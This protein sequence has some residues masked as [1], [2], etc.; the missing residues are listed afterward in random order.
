MSR[1]TSH[2]RPTAVPS[3]FTLVELLVVIGIIALLI[4]IL[5]PALS[6]ARE[7]G[8]AVK[9]MSNLRQ[10]YMGT[11]FYGLAFKGYTMP[12]TAGTGSAQNFN[13]WGIQVLGEAL[14]I[15]RYG[16]S[17]ADQQDTV[18][19]IAKMVD[20]P[21]N[22]RDKDPSISF[23]CDYTYNGNL[24]DFRAENPADSSYASYKPWAFF[25]KRVQV[26][27]TVVVA[28]DTA[29]TVSAND[30]RFASLGDLTTTSSSRPYPRAGNPHRGKA[31][32][33]FH[34]GSVRTVTA[35][36]P[37]KTP[38]TE[39]ADWMIRYPQPGDSASTIENNRW[40]K[41]RELPF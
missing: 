41:G 14:G 19:R 30:D 8:N 4:A 3:A 18:D 17:G 29:A 26:P 10:L 9:C 13:W 40:K 24:G 35:Y 22:I 11:E 25:K 39:L 38:N 31:N 28:L 7:Q 1:P 32:V 23:S 27:G 20:C 15:Q 33:L 36:D 16:N 34:D 5:L 21:S 12:S 6:R 2:R 37:T